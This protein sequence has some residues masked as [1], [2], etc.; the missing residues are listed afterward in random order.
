MSDTS[1][2]DNHTK[3]LTTPP[4]ILVNVTHV[5]GALP[6]CDSMSGAAKLVIIYINTL[7][8]TDRYWG[9]DVPLL[10]SPVSY[11][12]KPTRVATHAGTS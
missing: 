2:Y 4:A 10:L 11:S 9:S 5:T 8:H 3:G 6:L 7:V 12:I 1:D